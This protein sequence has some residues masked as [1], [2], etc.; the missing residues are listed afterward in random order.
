MPLQDFE[1]FV[2][3]S[4]SPVRNE[5]ERG[6]IRKFADAIGDPNP[7]YRDVEAAGGRLIAPPTF[8][9]TF[10]Y[11]RI[12]DLPLPSAGLIHGEQMFEY[13]RPIYSGDV[14]YCT[15]TLREVR[16]R[17]GRLGTMIFLV[18]DNTAVDETGELVVR[19]TLTVIC[20]EGG[21]SA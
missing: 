7:V 4:S 3:R 12:P 5:V 21:L 11:G 6:A 16:E 1:P 10:D 19:E 15:S 2:G 17:N 8:S 18:F 13:F 20:R 9:R 14:L